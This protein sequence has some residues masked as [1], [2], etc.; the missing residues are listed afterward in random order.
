M[1]PDIA[2][3]RGRNCAVVQRCIPI[4]RALEHGQVS[5]SLG[6]F[7]DGLHRG[8]AGADDSHALAGKID[9]LLGPAVGVAGHALER[10]DTRNV[11]RRWRRKNP[12][13]GDQ[14]AR[15]TAA[16]VFQRDLPAPRFFPVLCRG[17]AAVEL[18]VAQVE[19]VGHIIEIAFGVWLGGKALRPFPL[20]E[21]F[22]GK[23]VAVGVALGIEAGARIAVPVPGAPTAAPASEHPYPQ[24]KLAQFVELIKPETPAPMTTASKLELS[25]VATFTVFAGVPS[26]CLLLSNS[27]V[28]ALVASAK[29]MAQAELNRSQPDSAARLRRIPALRCL[30][31]SLTAAELRRRP[32]P[33]PSQRRRARLS[34]RRRPEISPS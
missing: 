8:R 20:V 5:D 17:D 28:R 3:L 18:D 10:A 14:E 6:Y 1:R 11:G 29:L 12:N 32:H 23:R 25:A 16:S 15:G 34:C 2:H 26:R 30:Q 22:L 7:L 4:G 9:F 13:G 31:A 19:L 21:Q 33:L 24:T 27:V